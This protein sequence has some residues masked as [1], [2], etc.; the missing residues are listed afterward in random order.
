MALSFRE[1]SPS[2]PTF[3]QQGSLSRDGSFKEHPLLKDGSFTAS[4]QAAFH[5]HLEDVAEQSEAEQAEV[6]FASACVI[7]LVVHALCSS[8][9]P[10]GQF[11][12][13]R[14][15]V[16]FCL[17]YAVLCAEQ[18]CHF[19][20]QSHLEDVAEQSEAEQAEVCFAL[21]SVILLFDS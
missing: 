12:K 17:F 3:A 11:C 21:A 15:T 7:L 5:S 13:Q 1:S 18:L 10:S 19:A 9:V 2:T 4:L 8:V 14:L 6:G 16:P 20:F